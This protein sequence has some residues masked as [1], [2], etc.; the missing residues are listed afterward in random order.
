[1]NFLKNVAYIFPV[2]FYYLLESFVISPMVYMLWKYLLFPTFKV[3]IG[4]F[5]W[6]AIIWIVK[7][8]FFDIFKL[9]GGGVEDLSTVSVNTEELETV[10]E[11]N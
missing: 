2:M 5:Q 7:V 9:I 8:L 4:Y 3:E 11:V 1:M 6:V 10:K